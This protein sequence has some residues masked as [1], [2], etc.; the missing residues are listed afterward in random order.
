MTEVLED[1][2]ATTRIAAKPAT[3][4]RY[5]TE[6]VYVSQWLGCLHYEK[7]VGHVFYMQHDK[8]KRGE[9]DLDGATHCRILA[10]EE[11]TTFTFSW[12]LPGTPETTV[13]FELAADGDGTVVTMTHD[14]WDRLDAKEM[15]A[16]RDMLANGWKSFVLPQLQRIVEKG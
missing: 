1:I 9:G 16:I 3:V 11:P 14:G 13:T 8:A 10:L 15:R 5:L 2:K 4:W 7:A 12:Y 6:P